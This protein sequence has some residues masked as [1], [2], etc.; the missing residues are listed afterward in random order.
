[1]GS[2]PNWIQNLRTWG[3]AGVV[4]LGKDGKTGDRG[5]TMMF[6]GYPSS[7]ES[8]SVRM[9]N[10]DTNRVVTT[11]DVIW[12][13]RMFF[14]IPTANNATLE[15]EISGNDDVE[16]VDE[17]IDANDTLESGPWEG[18]KVDVPVSRFGRAIKP[19]NRLIESISLMIEADSSTAINLRYL[20]QLAE[21]D[22]SEIAAVE[23]SCVG[24]GVGGGF[25]DSSKLKVM[26]YHQ[27]MKSKDKKEWELEIENEK[28]RFDKYS[29]LSP[30]PRNSIPK[31]GKVMT[32]TWA[33]KKKSNGKY[34]G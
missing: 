7:H 24:A 23:F 6:V 16:A 12:L 19:V 21:L 20:G 29:A 14:D 26:N 31:D 15:L 13:K 4:K 25:T 32:I 9:W 18:T 8:D 17:V 1:M 34:R 33:M 28:K 2:N 10:Q 5:S 11:R 30:V 3:E 22:Q 27:A